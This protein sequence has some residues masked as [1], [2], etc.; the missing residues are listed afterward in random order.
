MIGSIIGDIVGSIYEFHNIKTKDFPLFSERAEYTDD[1][2]LTIATA[3]WILEGGSLSDSGQYY[4]R[5]GFNYPHPMGAYG[6]SFVQWVRRAENGDFSPYNSCGNG[7]AMRVGPVG[8]A[9]NTKEEVL[10]AAKASAECTHNH[11]EGVK[12]AQAVALCIFMARNGASKDQIRFAME[13]ELG[14][15]LDF[16]CDGIRDDYDWHSSFGNGGTC[17]GSVPQ[18]IVAF[19]DGEDFEDCIRNAISIGGDSDTIG[20]ITGSIAEAYY[21]VPEDIYNEAY[22]RLTTHFKNVVK[23]F[24]DKY[25]RKII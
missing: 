19:L 2:I 21:G 16:T 4:Y 3:K 24:E 22:S 18:A 8:W 6:T 15:D 10:A 5:Y 20:C 23:E 11:P 1:S 7:S 9:Y 12:G 14:Y 13:K 17:Q 25:G